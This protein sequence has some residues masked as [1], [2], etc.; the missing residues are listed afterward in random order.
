MN[1]KF[2]E[3]CEYV[4]QDQAIESGQ[5]V[6]GP[7]RVLASSIPENYEAFREEGLPDEA[8][9]SE[10]LK[11][12]PTVGAEALRGVLDFYFQHQFSQHQPQPQP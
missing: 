7:T 3:G 4:K 12:F 1:A 10:T 8:A 11:C 6:V 2:W 9:F 5:P